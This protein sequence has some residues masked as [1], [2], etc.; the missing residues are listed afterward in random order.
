MALRAFF[1]CVFALNVCSNCV[2]QD[3][4]AM[5]QQQLQAGNNLAQQMQQYEQNI[6]QQNMQNPQV[7]AM[8][9]Q[10]L[11]QGGQMSFEQFAYSYAATGGFTPQGMQYHNQNER[12]IQQRESAAIQAYRQNQ[13]NNAQALQQMHESNANI[14]HHRGNLLNGTT[15]YVDPSTGQ[16]YNLPHTTQPNNYY[17]DQ[18]NQQM[19]YNDPSGN[20]H[21]E[22]QNG[23]WYQLQEAE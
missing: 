4:G 5:I 13:A 19:Y 16:Q 23:Y 8:Y 18:G 12:N 11:A 15:D 10:H 3:Y 14:A 2:A 20:Y 22:D 7:Q 17:Y 6:V 21:R 9:Q 1:L